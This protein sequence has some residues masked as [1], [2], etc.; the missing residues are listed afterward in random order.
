MLDYGGPYVRGPRTERHLGLIWEARS[1]P[2]APFRTFRG[3]KLQ[4]ADAA[5]DLVEAALQRRP[6]RWSSR[7]A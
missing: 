5:P 4:L 6:A 7:S 2:G 3:L 1:G